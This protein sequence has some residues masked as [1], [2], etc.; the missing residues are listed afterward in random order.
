MELKGEG[1]HAMAVCPGYVLTG[2]ADNALG[3]PPPASMKTQGAKPQG[4][5]SI[6]AS[7][8]ARA[9][10]R[11]VET[12]ASTVVTPGA[13]RL[14]IWLARLMPGMLESI[15]SRANRKMEQQA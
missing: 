12:N 5:M 4:W 13:G 7:E 2:F 8:C 6:T 3:G 15:M 1:I 9:V 10:A 11:G 14:L